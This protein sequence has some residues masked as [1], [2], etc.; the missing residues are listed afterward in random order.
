MAKSGTQ[1]N[2]VIDYWRG[3][4]WHEPVQYGRGRAMINGSV[5]VQ[6]SYADSNGYASEPLQILNYYV[7]TSKRD[8]CFFRSFPIFL[9][10][11]DSKK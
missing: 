7:Q 2:K 9:K 5:P 6:D 3:G 1:I 11:K 8:Q 4:H 10:E